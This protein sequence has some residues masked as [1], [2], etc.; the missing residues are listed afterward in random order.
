MYNSYAL[1]PVHQWGIDFTNNKSLIDPNAF[2]AT[3]KWLQ[4]IK[5]YASEATFGDQSITDLF[6]SNKL[7]FQIGG[8]WVDP[9]F[10]AAKANGLDYDYTFIPGVSADRVSDVNG[11]EY[12]SI[13]T[14]GPNADLAWQLLT[15]LTSEQNEWTMAQSTGQT[16]QNATAMSLVT[17]PLVKVVY[18]GLYNKGPVLFNSPPFFVEPYPDNYEQTIVNSMNAIYEGKTTPEAGTAQLIT[19][20]NGLITNR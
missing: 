11:G 1:D 8:P 4:S 9:T 7:A 3:A 6:T 14:K 10:E 13:N 20:L 19:T 2:I 5:P 18:E 17:N 16:N 15:W 12:I